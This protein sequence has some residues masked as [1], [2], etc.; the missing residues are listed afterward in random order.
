MQ[1]PRCQGFM[2]GDVWEDLRDNTGA[3][4]F[5]RWRCIL[6]G[7]V[8]DPII[9]T[10]RESR[11]RRATHRTGENTSAPQLDWPLPASHVPSPSHGTRLSP[12]EE[13]S[14]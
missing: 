1:C 6:C 14:P 8:V 12:A 3:C 2:V 4:S 5:T 9:L 7:E 10:N 13:G 11:P